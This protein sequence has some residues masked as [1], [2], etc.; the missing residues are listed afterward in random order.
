MS[1]TIKRITL[2]DARMDIYLCSLQGAI[3][4]LP[5]RSMTLAKMKNAVSTAHE[6]AALSV[7]TWD[8]H[9]AKETEEAQAH[10][11]AEWMILL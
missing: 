10:G 11:V 1:Q 7:K 6:I 8:N 2:C 9:V 5:R 4:A 3:A